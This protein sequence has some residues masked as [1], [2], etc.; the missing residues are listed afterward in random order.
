M[1]TFK[2]SFIAHTYRF[3]LVW[4]VILVMEGCQQNINTEKENMTAEILINSRAILGEGA[5]WNHK[6]RELFW[7]DIENGMFYIYQ[8]ANGNT[9]QFPMN[10]R[11]GTVVPSGDNKALVA[12]E[13]GIYEINIETGV[14]E[15]LENPDEN[16][17]YT[18]FNDGKCDP[19]GRFWV[20]TMPLGTIDKSAHLFRYDPDGSVKVVLDSI[21][22]SNGIVWS[23][24]HK[25]MYYIDTPT[26]QIKAFDYDIKTGNISPAGIAVTIPED[27][28]H[29]DG[30][31]IDEEDKL[32]VAHWG[33]FG[34]YR[35]DPETGRLM[36]KIS[37]PAKNVTSCTFGGEN[38]DVL[39]ITTA[40]TGNDP[41]ELAQYPASGGLFMARPGVKG[42]PLPHFRENSK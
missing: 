13:D 12:L 37:V 36:Q 18:R 30:M 3:L 22:I 41:K 1:T 5:F 35:W 15:F 2:N 25:K 39:Y 11:I 42:V 29:P 17:T 27:L 31:T 14:T 7:I 33:G 21:Q 16:T 23:S 38:L 24:D 9:I 20:G 40:R 6:T 4:L 10:K 8:P 19:A 34:V 28:G 26:S 32:W